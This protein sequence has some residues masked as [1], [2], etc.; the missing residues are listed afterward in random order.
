MGSERTILCG[1]GIRSSSVDFSHLWMLLYMN[2]TLKYK[3]QGCT[4]CYTGGFNAYIHAPGEE[5][6]AQALAQQPPVWKN[7]ESYRSKRHFFLA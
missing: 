4:N 6:P 2:G 1:A 3:Q 7:N 5:Y